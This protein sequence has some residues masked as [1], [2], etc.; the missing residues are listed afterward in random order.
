LSSYLLQSCYIMTQ[1][2]IRIRRYFVPY[3]NIS[4]GFILIYTFLHWLLIVQLK[5]VTP[6]DWVACI[7]LPVLLCGI[8]VLTG[9][10]IR[11]KLPATYLKSGIKMVRRYFAMMAAA[12]CLP[13][14]FVQQYMITATGKLT[15]LQTIDQV[16][17]YP[18]AR[19]YTVAEHFFDKAHAVIHSHTG[20]GQAEADNLL[21]EIY[22]ACPIYNHPAEN[23]AGGV[24]FCWLGTRYETFVTDNTKDNK[25]NR[26][27]QAFLEKV[28]QQYKDKDLSAFTY[29]ERV[30]ND[31]ASYRHYLK[32]ITAAGV[33]KEPPVVL[34]EARYTP[35][36]A[37]SGHQ[38]WRAVI[39]YLLISA[40]FLLLATDPWR[41]HD[42]ASANAV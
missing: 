26:E 18:P 4:L 17:T 2:Q 32:P 34:F 42:T 1:F 27:A 30:D 35:F 8:F 9:L 19:Y 31:G 36:A 10:K 22:V 28:Q 14:I 11:M 12:I 7:A 29:L 13:L 40:G 33:S 41:F 37:R 16:N 38:L 39:A 21:L 23:N 5:L 15:V 6:P 20:P 24:P 3:L 25:S